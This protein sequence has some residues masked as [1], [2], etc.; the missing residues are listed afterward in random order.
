M[1]LKT[2][3]GTAADFPYTFKRD[4]Q[5]PLSFKDPRFPEQIQQLAQQLGLTNLYFNFQ[6]HGIEGRVVGSDPHQRVDLKSHDGDYLI[7]NTPEVGI[8]V[9]TA[10]C[11]PIVFYAPHEQAVAV[12]HA[13]WKGSVA[14]IATVVV[15]RLKHEFNVN[16]ASLQ[17][18]FGAAGKVCC[19]EVKDDFITKLKAAMPNSNSNE[20]I[21]QRDG[22]Q[23][24]NNTL[25]NQRLLIAAGVQEKNIDLSHHDCT[26]CNHAYHSYRRAS[27]KEVYKAQATIAWLE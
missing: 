3:F 17:V 1:T 11:L 7:T 15:D 14:G 8:G 4:T 23:N 24:F 13:G 16:P 10:D 22:K 26:I 6:V 19:Y 5:P 20:L 9:F 25:L 12:A 21:V 2:F 18:W 27:D